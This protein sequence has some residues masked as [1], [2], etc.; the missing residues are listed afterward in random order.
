MVLYTVNSP[1]T[2]AAVC[3]GSGTAEQRCEDRRTDGATGDPGSRA[4]AGLTA[5][6]ANQRAANAAQAPIACAR[7]VRVGVDPD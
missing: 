3:P 5:A 4:D 6:S 2:A 7:S 1:H